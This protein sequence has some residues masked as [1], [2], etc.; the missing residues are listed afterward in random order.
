M[1][2]PNQEF[3]A[4]PP[5]EFQAPP[6]PP[7]P[8]PEAKP[9]RPP[10]ML[11]V[12]IVFFVLGLA[13]IVAG[14]ANLITGGVG[15]GIGVV[16]FSGLLLG[17]SFIR[18]P[19]TTADAPA[20]LSVFEKLAGIF[21]EPSRVFKNLRSH[22][23]WLV[24]FLIVALLNV[25]YTA[26]FTQRLT[27]EKV[28]GYRVEKLA[29]SPIMPAEAIEGS[30]QQA[31]Q[32]IQEARMPGKK[33]TAAVSG[34][35]VAFFLMALFAALYL[36][37]MLAFGGRMN[38]WQAFAV[39]IYSALPVAII[40]KILSLLLLYIKSP[41]DVHPILNADSLVQDNF[42]LLITP[43]DHPVFFVAASF[44][45]VLSFYKLW[46]TANGLRHGSYRASSGAAWGVA[47]TLW[48]LG[49]VL[50]IALAAALPSFFT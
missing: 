32:E 13:I 29:E 30:K 3:P 41:E 48:I 43:A 46:L 33:V 19:A 40:Q 47:L 27:P 42:G 20:P 8:E 31:Q 11:M 50:S 7:A 5:Q 9:P 28:I 14:I 21:Y 45:G 16:F 2:D 4:P 39:A 44:I 49:L 25:V 6:P 36:L 35:V 38:F 10:R 15:A 17:L 24:A 12:A 1:S 26:A 34:L 22:P 18:L 37:G 23:R